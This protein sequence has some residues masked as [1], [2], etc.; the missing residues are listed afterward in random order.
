MIPEKRSYSTACMVS[1]RPAVRSPYP[2][3][4]RCSQCGALGIAYGEA[5]E[6]MACGCGGVRKRLKPSNTDNADHGY[7]LS[8]VV[9]GGMEHNAIRVSVEKDGHPLTGDH[10]VEWIAIYTY[11]G[12]QIKFLQGTLSPAALFAMA[13]DDAYSFCNRKVCRMGWEHCQFQCKRGWRIYG[14]L[15]GHGLIQ[16]EL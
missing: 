2:R 13:G 3:F 1:R 4:Y 7:S 15:G 12:L 11:E 14:W 10:D 16:R 8:F 6:E 5:K 9:F